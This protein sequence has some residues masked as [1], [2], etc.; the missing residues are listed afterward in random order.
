MIDRVIKHLAILLTE[1]VSAV[2]AGLD[3]VEEAGKGERERERE[4]WLGCLFL[5]RGLT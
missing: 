1:S 5:L 3:K 2:V 4:K